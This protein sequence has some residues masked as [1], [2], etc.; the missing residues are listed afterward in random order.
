MKISGFFENSLVSHDFFSRSC[1]MRGCFAEADMGGHMMFWWSGCLIRCAMFRKNINKTPKTVKEYSCIAIS[2]NALLVFTDLQ[3]PCSTLLNISSHAKL[4]WSLLVFNFK[5]KCTSEHMIF[6]LILD[7]SAD[8]TWFDSSLRFLLDWDAA[9]NS[10]LVF[11]LGM[12]C[13]YSDNE[14]GNCP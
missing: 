14:D 6:P 3:L 2:C 7:N 13:R 4:L 9:T 8:L 5:E 12:N 10:C 1:L 11:A